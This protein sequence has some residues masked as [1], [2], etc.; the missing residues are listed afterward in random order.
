MSNY[1]YLQ[2]AQRVLPL[3]IC[4]F[5]QWGL[6]LI[7]LCS[8]FICSLLVMLLDVLLIK[9]CH[10]H[11]GKIRALCAAGPPPAAK[12]SRVGATRHLAFRA[13]E[14]RILNPNCCSSCHSYRARLLFSSLI[15]HAERVYRCPCVNCRKKHQVTF[16]GIIHLHSRGRLYR[17]ALSARPPGPIAWQWGCKWVNL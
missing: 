8:Y 3:Y 9:H 11:L 5:L 6:S 4:L 2:W 14:V 1:A 17:E 13:S 10:E 16:Y 15:K 7:T 12:E